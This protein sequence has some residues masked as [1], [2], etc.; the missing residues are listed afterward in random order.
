MQCGW[1]DHQHINACTIW[2]QNLKKFIYNRRHW[3]P[4]YWLRN[5]VPYKQL[6]QH[7]AYQPTMCRCYC[8]SHQYIHHKLQRN[9]ALA[10]G[11]I[12]ASCGSSKAV[13]V[14]VANIGNGTSL[15][16]ELLLIEPSLI[17]IK[18]M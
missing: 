3:P 5:S 10:F 16:R 6:R 15:C 18:H 9:M 11:R 4:S 13:M 2:N 12:R 1:P 7:S 17:F 14:F 8:P